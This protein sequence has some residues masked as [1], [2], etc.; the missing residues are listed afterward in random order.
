MVSDLHFAPTEGAGHT[1]RAENVDPSSIH[2]T[3]NTVIDA[4]FAT[5]EIL[6]ERPELA[7]G[8]DQIAQAY[9]AQH[10][11]LLV[12]TRESASMCG[13]RIARAPNAPISPRPRSSGAPT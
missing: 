12:P 5:R 2:V 6:R 10:A 3:G 13:V 4:L 11:A 8:L 7:S 1:L 9:A